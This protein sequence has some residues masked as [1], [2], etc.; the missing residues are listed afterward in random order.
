MNTMGKTD[1][2][3]ELIVRYLSGD[4]DPDE[5][6]AVANWLRVEENRSHFSEFA[7][8]WRQAAG[9][10]ANLPDKAGAWE[11]V[12]AGLHSTVDRGSRSG[13][14]RKMLLGSA[15]AAL[16]A[17]AIASYFLFFNASTPPARPLSSVATTDGFRFVEFADRSTVTLNRHTTLQYPDQFEG[18]RRVILAAGEAFFSV[19]TD[20]ARPFIVEAKDVQITVLGTE[21]D[22]KVEDAAVTVHVREGRVLVS[23]PKTN[24]T[25]L[26]GQTG[27]ADN[28]HIAVSDHPVGNLYSYATQR[29]VFDDAPL[30]E[31]IRD[32]EG[33]YPYTF[34]LR[35]RSL[36]NCRITANFYKDDIDKIVNLVAETLNLTVS[37][38]GR[39]FTLEGEG[40][41]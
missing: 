36:E 28:D 24:A 39:H 32:L 37:K 31:V 12:S 1:V 19:A 27:T 3:D 11:R 4:A 9:E 7:T 18:S 14:R 13:S 5:A 34:E 15:A 40:C 38:D 22:V 20:A 16:F 33:S 23:T 26:T 35:N 6:L 30:R 25:L 21:F 41:L 8:T 29:L 17:I 2:D 10:T